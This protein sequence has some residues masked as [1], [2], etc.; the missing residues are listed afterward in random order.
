MTTFNLLLWRRQAS[1]AGYCLFRLVQVKP[2]LWWAILDRVSLRLWTCSIVFMILG[3]G[4]F[5]R[6]SRYSPSF[7]ES[8]EATWGLF[9]RIL[10][11][12][13]GP[14]LSNVAMNQDQHWSGCGPRCLE[15]V[16]AW[17]FVER[18]EKGM[19]H[20]V[21]EKDPP[22]QVVSAN[23]FPLRGR[24][25]WIRKFWFWMRQLSHRY[26]NRR[27]HPTGYGSLA[28]GRTTFIIAHRLS[29]IQDADQILVLSEGRIVE[30]GRHQELVHKAGS[31]PR[32]ECHPANSG[33][34]LSCKE[35]IENQPVSSI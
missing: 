23:W 16:G 30:R 7:R 14:L 13:R 24:S 28:K 17:P 1:S 18:L 22:F 33:V 31:M 10:I 12:L 29:T 2:S 5:D 8:R 26:G 27:N 4:D 6:W 3:R 35:K 15:K 34:R 21:V 11:Y 25:I 9:R 19:D 32:D 20:P